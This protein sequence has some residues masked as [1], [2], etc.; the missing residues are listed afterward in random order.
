MNKKRVIIVEDDKLLASVLK[1]MAHKL[2]LDVIH[3]A[4]TGTDAVEK[5][6]QESPDL[7]F[8]DILL[9]DNINGID[10]MKKIREKISSPVIYISA[11]SDHKVRSDA[12]SVSN[13]YYMQK[14]VDLHELKIA[15][16]SS[17]Q[18]A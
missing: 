10:A 8:M 12:A 2:N 13:S 1:R 3:V 7:I 18:A 5:I 14:P 17:Q 15:I 6:K 16:N 11:L 4:S 9:A